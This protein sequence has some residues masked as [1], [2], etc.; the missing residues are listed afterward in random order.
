MARL[1]QIDRRRVAAVIGGRSHGHQPA[2]AQGADQYGLVRPLRRQSQIVGEAGPHLDLGAP[3]R[4][5]AAQEI[6]LHLEL[7]VAEQQHLQPV[8]HGPAEVLDPARLGHRPAGIGTL[9]G[10]AAQPID[11]LA[12]IAAV[13][14][15]QLGGHLGGLVLGAGAG[16]DAALHQ[17]RQGAG[18]GVGIQPVEGQELGQGARHV[19]G[20]AEPFEDLADLGVH[21]QPQLADCV[22]DQH[23]V[24]VQRGQMHIGGGADQHGA[25]LRR[26]HCTLVNDFC[27]KSCGSSSRRAA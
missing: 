2:R 18:Q 10:L 17:R 22:Q 15:L 4:A 1:V 9:L 8:A 23:P 5:L 16:Q 3:G 27:L 19:A 20:L 12:G 11:R 13:Q 26:R 14:G 7:A 24:L 6:G 25:R 21:H